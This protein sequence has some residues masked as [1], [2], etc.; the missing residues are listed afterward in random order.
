MWQVREPLPQRVQGNYARCVF[1]FV[2]LLSPSLVPIPLF[3]PPPLHPSF[4]P[5]VVGVLMIAALP[6][7]LVFWYALLI[8]QLGVPRPCTSG[9]SALAELQR[10]CVHA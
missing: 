7:P 2:I 4:R 8:W 10:V 6:V 1:L 9:M 5:L 3:R